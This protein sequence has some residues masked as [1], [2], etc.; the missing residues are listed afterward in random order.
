VYPLHPLNPNRLLFATKYG[1]QYQISYTSAIYLIPDIFRFYASFECVNLDLVIDVNVGVPKDPEIPETIFQN[2]HDRGNHLD[3]AFI[4]ICADHDQR[5]WCRAPYFE[6]WES[7]WNQGRFIFDNIDIEYENYIMYTGIFIPINLHDAT[8]IL[9]E[10]NQAMA[11]LA[12]QNG[13]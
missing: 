4:Y 9:G 7:I 5:A 6:K 11:L 1:R 13:P 10:Y 8:G 3:L 12:K 2:M